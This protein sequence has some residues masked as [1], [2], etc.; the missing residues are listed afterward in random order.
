MQAKT[1]RAFRTISEAG[2][3]LSLQPHVL[4][5]W[6]SKF[7]QIKP[8]KRGGG[9]RFYRPEDIEFLRGIK[10]LLHDEKHPIKDVQKLIRVKGAGR[11]IELGQSVQKAATE[12]EVTETVLIP[13]RIQKAEVVKSLEV[14]DE[15]VVAFIPRKE[16]KPASQ[17]SAAHIVEYVEEEEP[18]PEEVGLS[19][20]ERSDLEGALERLVSLRRRW[21]EF[22]DAEFKNPT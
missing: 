15:R 18:V 5:F 1:T 14:E 6:E 21:L 4:R 12:K 16:E 2:E 10:I 8:I 13:E 17:P 22:K 3:E 20:E 9:R 19:T 11:V 7:P